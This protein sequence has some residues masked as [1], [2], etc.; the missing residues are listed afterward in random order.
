MGGLITRWALTELEQAGYDH[1]VRMWVSFDSP[2][3]GA[4]MPTGLQWLVHY[5]RTKTNLNF[6]G[7]GYMPPSALYSP[8]AK[9]MLVHHVNNRDGNT[10]MGGAPGFHEHFYQA[11]E[12]QGF[13]QN[14]RKLALVNGSFMGEDIGIPGDELLKIKGEL[15]K[16][17]TLRYN[18]FE[19]I[20]KYSNSSLSKTYEYKN[21]S[22]TRVLHVN[23]H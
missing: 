22:F 18:I 4:N 21:L 16:N 20:L 3:Q 19:A 15:W 12:Q 13:P 8:A 23:D 17:G 1:K 9:Q 5:L 2:H 14:T 11:L 7:L 10:I 6:S